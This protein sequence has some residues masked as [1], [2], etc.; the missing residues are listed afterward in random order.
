[1]E[2][3]LFQNTYFFNDEDD[4]HGRDVSVDKQSLSAIYAMMYQASRQAGRDY[5]HQELR[6]AALQLGQTIAEGFMWMDG[7]TTD[8]D[9]HTNAN[10][11][12][13]KDRI[14][15]DDDTPDIVT[16]YFLPNVNM[17]QM[18]AIAGNVTVV[19]H[20]TEDEDDSSADSEDDSE[21]GSNS[22]EDSD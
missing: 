3:F 21:N 4:P 12:A 18:K 13:L 19:W 20:D 14:R 2:N 6:G 8:V 1:M 9:T 22:S 10:M 11:E 7:L 17:S 15:D 16:S 5:N